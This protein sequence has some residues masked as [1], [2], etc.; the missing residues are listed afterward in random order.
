M[1][2]TP[3]RAHLAKLW[4]PSACFCSAGEAPV[5]TLEAREKHIALWVTSK[6]YHLQEVLRSSCVDR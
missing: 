5:E 3:A 6:V 1:D 2:N 4:H